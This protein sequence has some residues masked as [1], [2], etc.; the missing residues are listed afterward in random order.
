MN[1][2]V[3]MNNEHIVP[4]ANWTEFNWW[5]TFVFVKWLTCI[6]VT[7]LILE[8]MAS[9]IQRIKTKQFVWFL[10]QLRYVLLRFGSSYHTCYS[11]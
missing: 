4:A 5:L 2:A 9:I 3:I 1:D 7:F 8:V 10:Q 11:F 6:E